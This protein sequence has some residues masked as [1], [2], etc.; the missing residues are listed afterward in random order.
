MPMATSYFLFVTCS[1]VS[2]RQSVSVSPRYNIVQAVSRSMR[3]IPSDSFPTKLIGQISK[4]NIPSGFVGFL[5]E[6]H[7]FSGNS[8]SNFE[9]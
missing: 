1:K 2:K 7:L 9:I 3:K 6:A 5:S 8:T 4:V